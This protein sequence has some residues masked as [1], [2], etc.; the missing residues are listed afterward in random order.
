MTT[1]FLAAR[2][3]A[4]LAALAATALLHTPAQAGLISGNYDPDFGSALPGLRWAARVE[5]N[6]PNAC[7]DLGG[8]QSTAGVDCAGAQ[9]LAVFLRLF[10]TSYTPVDWSAPGAYFSASPDL[11]AYGLCSNA[12][13]SDPAYTSRCFG[14]VGNYFSLS[15]LRMEGGNVVGLDMGVSTIF[16]TNVNLGSGQ[17]LVPT[18]AQGNTFTLS[19]G[20]TGPNLVCTTCPG[21]PVAS[22]TDGLRQFLITYTSNNTSQ[23]KYTDAAGNPLGALLDERGRVLGL[24]TSIDSQPV[25]EPGSLALV[26]TALAAAALLRRRRPRA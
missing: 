7:I 11:L 25:P 6:V 21:G 20:L 18:S 8:T 14:N 24:A 22:Q 12:V 26:A 1:P 23:P 3:L 16:P 19:F 17:E 10:N 15:A 13:S 4:T 2:P 9:V 5:L